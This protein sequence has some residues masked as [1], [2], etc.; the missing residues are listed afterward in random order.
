MIT[1]TERE[2]LDASKEIGAVAE[3]TSWA[4]ADIARLIETNGLPINAM[5]VGE[6]REVIKIQRNKWASQS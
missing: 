3:M 5:T 4:S 2:L 1:A 6:L